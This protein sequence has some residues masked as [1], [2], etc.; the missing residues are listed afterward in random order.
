MMS[1]QGDPVSGL[2]IIEQTLIRIM[3]APYL[4][5]CSNLLQSAAMATTAPR[6]INRQLLAQA[7]SAGALFHRSGTEQLE[8][9]ATLGA[10]VEAVMSLSAVAKLKTLGRAPGI[11]A[12]IARA[13]TPAANKKLAQLLA[14]QAYPQ[15][16]ADPANPAV[17][18]AYTRDQ[19]KA[20]N[21]EPSPRP[22][23]MQPRLLVL[24]GP[25]G[26]GKSTFYRAYLQEC[27]L[28]FTQCR[29]PAGEYGPGGL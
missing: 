19:A 1:F 10:A 16:A 15:Y 18:V 11:D 17:V 3:T 25:N 9:W 26:A 24:A 4:D 14:K 8:H 20:A 27:G 6:R 21:R 22:S 5:S 13:G 29:C 7:E 28:P 2:V 12:L 23:A